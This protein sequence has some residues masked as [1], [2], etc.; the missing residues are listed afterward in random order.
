MQ[1]STFLPSRL[2]RRHLLTRVG[3][4]GF[5]GLLGASAARLAMSSLAIAENNVK[6]IRLL[7]NSPEALVVLPEHGPWLARWAA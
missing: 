6:K 4:M 3:G 2:T 5:T 1:R 7:L